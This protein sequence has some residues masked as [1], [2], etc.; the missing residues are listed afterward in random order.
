MSI[1][2]IIPIVGQLL[3]LSLK[4]AD[5]IDKADDV[6]ADDKEAL[7]ALIRQAKEGVTYWNEPSTDTDGGGN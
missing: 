5:I 3:T 4:V 2:L 6:S 1:A 7:K